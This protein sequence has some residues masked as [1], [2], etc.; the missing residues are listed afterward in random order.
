MTK[1]IFSQLMAWTL[2]F[3]LIFS[4]SACG[5]KFSEEKYKPLAEEKS[6]LM[7]EIQLLGST[8]E[9]ARSTHEKWAN[10]HL[11]TPA[12]KTEAEATLKT[13]EA[14]KKTVSTASET[15]KK[16]EELEKKY[17]SGE[18]SNEDIEKEHGAIKDGLN[19][20][21][22]DYKK[23]GDDYVKMAEAHK[24]TTAPS[25]NKKVVTPVKK[26]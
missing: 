11:K 6:T 26:K 14:H 16:N 10:E 25:N 19:A 7:K 23:M 20:I 9:L 15:F 8:N 24:S 12:T 21:L 18:V 2:M 22:A 3:V 13:I 17:L 1:G 4:F 5:K